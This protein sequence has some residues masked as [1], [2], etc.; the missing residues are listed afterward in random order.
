[1]G[2]RKDWDMN[3]IRH[4]LWVMAHEC[5]SSRNDGFTQFEIKKELLE[6]KFLVDDLLDD[7]PTFAGEDEIYHERLLKKLGK[8]NV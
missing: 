1:M 6:I 8:Q 3:A 4:S 5:S 2:F 7:S